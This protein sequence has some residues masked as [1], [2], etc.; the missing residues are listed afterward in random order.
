MDDE[1][2]LLLSFPLQAAEKSELGRWEHEAGN[3]TII[4][5]DW[6]IAHVDGKTER[7]VASAAEILPIGGDQESTRGSPPPRII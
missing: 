1:T 3:V 5:D 2:K 4:R 6:G 7:G